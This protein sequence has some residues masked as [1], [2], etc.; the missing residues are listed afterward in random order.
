M[1]QVSHTTQWL[2]FLK[3]TNN[4][5]ERKPWVRK[6]GH[7]CQPFRASVRAATLPLSTTKELP[8]EALQ[9]H[10]TPWDPL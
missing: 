7:C 1:A 6:T 10:S 3:G 2:H 5:T 8:L 4:T 9:L